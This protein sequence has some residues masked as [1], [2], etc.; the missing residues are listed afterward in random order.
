MKELF[1]FGKGKLK[2]NILGWFLVD[3]LEYGAEEF[4]FCFIFLKEVRVECV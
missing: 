1:E 4:G 3:E 2:L